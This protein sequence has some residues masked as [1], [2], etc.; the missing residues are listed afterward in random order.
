M[1]KPRAVSPRASRRDTLHDRQSRRRT[2][3]AR[4]TSA[5]RST[6]RCR[7]SSSATNAS[8]RQGCL[9][10]RRHGPC[11]HRDADGRR[12]P[13]RRTS[14]QKRA[15]YSRE[16][17]VDKVWE[18]KGESGGQ[19]TRQLRR[20]G[21]RC[22]WARAV[23]DGP[24]FHQGGG[25]GVRRPAQKGLLYRDKR[26]VNWDPRSRPRSPT[27]RSRPRS[28]VNGQV[29]APRLPRWRDGSGARSRSRRRAPR[30]CSPTWRWR[31]IPMTN[32]TRR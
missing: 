22:D 18:W 4:C 8:A 19:I 27:S 21:A 28:R 10:G 24:A 2:S 16:Q 13:A 14:G 1:G 5:M 3:P 31:C 30:R 32:A 20:L 25:Q 26:L 23:H 6:I 9:V 7:T 17:F 11:R 29:L 12:A 15:D